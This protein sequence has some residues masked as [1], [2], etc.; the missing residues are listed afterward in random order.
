MHL[1]R[2]LPPIGGIPPRRWLVSFLVLGIAYRLLRWAVG[3][4]FWG[5]EV[6]LALNFFDRDAGGIF[7]PLEN[8]QVAPPFFVLYVWTAIHYLGTSE[9][10]L[11]AISVAAGT[12]GIFLFARLAES[13]LRPVEAMFGVAVLAVSYYTVTYDAELKPYALDLLVSV[14]IL[15]ISL[16]LAENPTPWVRAAFAVSI[17]TAELCSYPAVFVVASVLTALS[18]RSWRRRDR[19][20]LVFVLG[21]GAATLLLFALEYWWFIGPQRAANP[22][23]GH[24]WSDAFPPGGLLAG[25]VW[26][27]RET[28]GR[29][30]AYPVGGNHY[31]SSITLAAVA[32]GA[33][34]LYRRGQRFELAIL[35]LP[36]AFHLLAATLGAYPY[37]QST[38]IA[39]HLA[40]SI[41]LLMGAGIAALFRARRSPSTTVSTGMAAVLLFF[42][43]LGAGGMLATILKPYKSKG[44]LDVRTAVERSVTMLQCPRLDIANPMRFTPVNFLWYLRATH[45]ARFS[46]DPA[47]LLEKHEQRLCLYLFDG[48]RFPRLD[49]RVDALLRD[50]VGHYR[51]AYDETRK[52]Y[53]Y[54]G[55]EHP[56]RYRLIVLQARPDARAPALLRRKVAKLGR[57]ARERMTCRRPHCDGASGGIRRFTGDD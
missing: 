25:L 37:G 22:S 12:A 14:W 27:V 5:D 17:M 11:R 3:M 28:A 36:F 15:S 32:V 18:W 33:V 34:A 55:R 9:W 8:G 13:L 38:R 56:H 23:L 50:S 16:R 29:M 39:Q 46:V 30:L 7:K 54:R 20:V 43:L 47:A 6:M 35:L 10:T 1:L 4:P 48:D 31:A 19:G 53:I 24:Y 57:R 51:V 21:V 52:A 42:A 26:V 44:A 41:C 40:P 45:R 49:K 2:A